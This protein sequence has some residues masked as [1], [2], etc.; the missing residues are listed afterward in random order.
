MNSIIHQAGLA[1]H[2]SLALLSPK[3]TFP[4]SDEALVLLP[5]RGALRGPTGTLADVCLNSEGS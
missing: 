1:P 2:R 5:S 4:Y 3:C